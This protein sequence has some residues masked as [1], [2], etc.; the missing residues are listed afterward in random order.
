MAEDVFKPVGPL[1]A[2]TPDSGG[3][4]PVRTVPLLGIVKDNIDPNRSGR[5]FV[6]LSDNS[7][8]DPDD[9]NNWVK[10]DF[11]SPFFGQTQSDA[12]DTGYGTYKDNPSSYGFWN[13]PPDIGTTVV[14]LFLNGDQ[15]YGFYIGAI[16]NP[17]ALQMVPAI[18]ATE[19]I[20]PNESE[21]NSYGGAVRLPVTNINTNNSGISDS[22][23][24]ISAAK[25]IHS[26]ESS[27][28]FQQGLLRDPIRG[29]ISTSAQRETPSRVGW[30]I[31]TPG[32]PIYEGGYTDESI[33]AAASE[34]QQQEKLKIISR[35]TGHSIVLDDGDIIGRDRL[36][37]IRSALGHQ[38]LMSDD[39][40]TLFIIHS[41]GQSYIELGKEGTVDI[42]S[43]NSFN[44]RTQGDIN[45]H[46]D[47]N[48]N[49]NAAKAINVQTESL[50]VNVDKDF[51][52]RVGSNYNINTL[53][54][55]LLK[56]QGA[57]SLLSTGEASFRSD[58]TTFINGS[59]INLNTGK[60]STVPKDVAPI[61]IIAQDDTL[62]DSVKGYVAAPNSL[63]T[64]VSRC[65]AHTPWSQ[66]NQGVSVKVT[67]SA[68]SVLP[69]P[70]SPTVEKLNQAA[71]AAELTPTT[72]T[73]TSTVPNLPAVSSS[74][75]VATTATSI[76]QQAVIAATGT[77]SEAVK[78]GVGVVTQ[79]AVPEVSVGRLA[80]TPTQLQ[81]AGYLK[82]GSAP[83]VNSLIASGRSPQSS[84]TN[85]LFTG[86][87]GAQNLGQVVTNV[88]TQTMGV[89]KNLQQ[90]Q[91]ALQQIGVLTGRES[92][93]QS[94]GVVMAGVTAGVSKVTQTLR[95]VQGVSN[96]ASAVQ[97]GA[98]GNVLG[99]VAAGTFAASLSQ[100]KIKG[101]AGITQAVNAANK[102]QTLAGLQVAAR[103]AAAAAFDSILKGFKP[104]KPGIPQ[105][106]ASIAKQNLS[107]GVGYAA[108][109][110]ILKNPTGNFSL[111][112][113]ATQV[114]AGTLRG[115]SASIAS[116]MGNL[117][118]GA[119]VAGAIINNALGAVN[120]IPGI[121]NVRG[122]TASTGTSVLNAISPSNLLSSAI[123]VFAP[124][125][126]PL[127]GAAGSL[128]GLANKGL[129]SSGVAQLSG[130]LGALNFGGKNSVRT[131]TIGT[132]TY[133]RTG[134][135]NQVTS[136]LGDPRIPSPN[137]TGASQAS[138]A[139]AQQIQAQGEAIREITTQLDE[140]N[141]K[142]NAAKLN[143]ENLQATLP[144]GD[145]AVETAKQEWLD[146]LDDP[147]RTTLLNQLKRYQGR[148]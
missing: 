120:T 97:Q 27:I 78:R 3:K 141:A 85:N 1:K 93:T 137:F 91:R 50:N 14:C 99:I 80:L 124:A 57:M 69:Q 5:I 127:L 105:N 59:R 43:T 79:G 38:I 17:S 132:N 109:N 75:D 42:F 119:R 130:A 118:G 15:N 64:I 34:G 70:A 13:S 147:L 52:Q 8:K 24:F 143:Y 111:T 114:A 29:P 86:I 28:M 123:N 87:P 56:S 128:V 121:N 11:L 63:L 21:A 131:P 68:D 32:R 36:V 76:S 98:S 92:S 145:P 112:D 10:M 107:A 4:A 90:S 134:L 142:T 135:T 54:N 129:A 108:V 12:N 26:Y 20:V 44:V 48:I 136:L 139:T 100:S 81:N 37:R 40:Q 46:A 7:G 89:V 122:L 51:N 2:A 88:T 58:V 94:L 146:Y 22:I 83:L 35:R 16:P 9:S 140:L 101:L 115:A 18:G 103:G 49:L 61:P 19:N 106:L 62:Y 125:V 23:D 138:I 113:I 133:D 39:G 30:G 84:M 31:S 126:N 144:T 116:G 53:S 117:P 45:F 102:V 65:P 41:N 66:A 82:P 77:T 71:Q 67:A 55:F 47:N 6:Y 110:T 73:L 104:L 74:I 33:A 25:P 148:G 95:T 60:A 96:I 72:Q